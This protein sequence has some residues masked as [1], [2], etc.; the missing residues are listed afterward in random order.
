MEKKIIEVLRLTV[1]LARESES[2]I[3]LR[4]DQIEE[5][6]KK[7][8]E[9]AKYVSFQRLIQSHKE[10]EITDALNQLATEEQGEISE[11]DS[12]SEEIVVTRE[13]IPELEPEPEPP[14]LP[15]PLVPL[16]QERDPIPVIYDEAFAI[17]VLEPEVIPSEPITMN[18]IFKNLLLTP[19]VTEMFVESEVP[20]PD[21]AVQDP[22][23]PDVPVQD[24]NIPE[25]PEVPVQDPNIPDVPEIPVTS[26]VPPPDVP[27]IPVASEVPPPDVP[28]QQERVHVDP[29]V[30]ERKRERILQKFYVKFMEKYIR[31]SPTSSISLSKLT[32]LINQVKPL[33]MDAMTERDVMNLFFPSEWMPSGSTYVCKGYCID[34]H[35]NSKTE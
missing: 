18:Y 11:D 13:K 29:V 19:I 33:I 7:L 14:A 3:N 12:E 1:D 22:N 6:L 34:W 20:L 17:P 23:I 30:L 16:P 32:T 24:P 5:R 8:E 21:A 25:V 9:R 10:R 31:E 28:V 15:A 2:R 35:K 26:D 4:L 27:E